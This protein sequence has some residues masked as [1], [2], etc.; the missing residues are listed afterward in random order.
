MEH[1][2]FSAKDT[3]NDLNGSMKGDATKAIV[4]K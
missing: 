3:G 4:D 1:T 2:A